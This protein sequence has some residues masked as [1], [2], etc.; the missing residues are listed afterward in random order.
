MAKT[1]NVLVVEDAPNYSRLA[2]AQ[3]E[4]WKQKGGSNGFDDYAVQIEKLPEQVLGMITDEIHL[5]VLDM[6]LDDGSGGY[7]GVTDVLVPARKK[8]YQGAVL[9]WTGARHE[10][11]RNYQ[12]R[13]TDAGADGFVSKD[14]A[15][16]EGVFI[17]EVNSALENATKRLNS[18]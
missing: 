12:K 4:L 8:G 5:V 16:K 6:E 7:D 2:R 10:R 9:G 13:A 15:A 14:Q 18:K 3:L 11:F 1:L 17:Q